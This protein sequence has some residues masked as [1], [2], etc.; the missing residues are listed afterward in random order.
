MQRAK[1]HHEYVEATVIFV[2]ETPIWKQSLFENEL[3]QLTFSENGTK[4]TS[5]LHISKFEI[6][7]FLN[8]IH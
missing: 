4:M 5:Q 7:I 8:K 1:I 3:L 2:L 6:F